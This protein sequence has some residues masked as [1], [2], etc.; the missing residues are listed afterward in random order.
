[1]G[2]INIL[3]SERLTV[4][5]LKGFFSALLSTGL[6]LPLLLFKRLVRLQLCFPRFRP[7]SWKGFHKSPSDIT[8]PVPA[9]MPAD[10][11]KDS[12]PLPQS[13]PMRPHINSK[14]KAVLVPPRKRS[15]KR[16]SCDHTE[17]PQQTQAPLCNAAHEPITIHRRHD[18]AI[19]TSQ[20]LLDT[21][22]MEHAVRSCTPIASTEPFAAS[23][24]ARGTAEPAG[25]VRRGYGIS[26]QEL[27]Y[28]SSDESC[29]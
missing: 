23:L 12:A 27:L 16:R 8:R 21:L 6:G 22:V 4:S 24:T 7:P 5:R 19:Q 20:S 28:S 3:I 9:P 1:M 13:L 11:A 29:S 14:T 17:D 26:S 25:T 18:R 2:H 15:K 10:G